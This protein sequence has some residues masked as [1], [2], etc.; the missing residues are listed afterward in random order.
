MA[1]LDLNSISKSFGTAKVL[2]DISLAIEDKE[3]VVFVGPSGC[4]KSTLLRIIAGL[5]EATEGKILIGGNDVS[6]AHPVD[7]G[8]SM[9]F[10]SY[11]LYPHLSVYENIAFPLRV[12]KMEKG[13]LDQRVKRAAEILQLTDKLDLKPGQL[14]GGQRQRVAIGRSIVRNP[15]VFLFDE[16][17]SNLDA[18]LRGDMRVE[19]S[20]LHRDLDATMVYVTHDQVEAMTMADRI[21]VLN[22]GRVEQFG[23]PMELYHHPATKFVAGFIGQP[24]MNFIPSTVIDT[25][26][27]LSVE[28]KGGHKM[29]LPVDTTT[30]SKGDIVEVGVRPED[31][32]IGTT[33]VEVEVRVLERLGGASI[34]YGSIGGDTRFCASLPGD[35]RVKEGGSV[36]LE[37]K[38]E[39]C[40]VFDANGYVLRRQAA[41]EL[42]A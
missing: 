4:G 36:T 13:E 23:T 19:L 35:V 34:S 39:D 6:D 18:A 17:L 12:Q 29:V 31:V 11:A 27:G 10:Q 20:Q 15:K 5:E 7:R 26:N 14:S 30:V 32:T 9:V 16:P 22:G 1:T 33:G 42:V 41:P 25:A 38:P 21:V 28:L 40:H 8:I 24:N 37:I 3:F 2:H